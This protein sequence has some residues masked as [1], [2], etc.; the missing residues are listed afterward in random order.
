VTNVVGASGNFEER[1]NNATV[2]LLGNV[3]AIV[4]DGGVY[5]ASDVRDALETL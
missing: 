5:D 1:L 3:A 2:L 4:R